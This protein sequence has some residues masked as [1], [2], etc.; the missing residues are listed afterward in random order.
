MWVR[1]QGHQQHSSAA[2][3]PCAMRA[4]YLCTPAPLTLRAAS[5]CTPHTARSCKSRR[6][7]RNSG[8]YMLDDR[9]LEARGSF[10][11]GQI[12]GV[13]RRRSNVLASDKK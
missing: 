5:L 11:A 6:C 8:A 1:S 3:L 2:A 4:D 7:H 9:P 13:P 10:H 12:T